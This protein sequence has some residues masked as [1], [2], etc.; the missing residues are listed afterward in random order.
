MTVDNSRY[1]RV[2]VVAGWV[3]RSCPGLFSMI[4]NQDLISP[5]G[6][7]CSDLKYG[8]FTRAGHERIPPFVFLSCSSFSYQRSVRYHRK[9]NSNIFLRTSLSP[10]VI[11]SLK[12]YGHS[13]LN[14]PEW[15]W[16]IFEPNSSLFPH[17]IC[18]E[19]RGFRRV[20]WQTAEQ[21]LPLQ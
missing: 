2:C 14:S 19:H 10:A 17:D 12:A 16:A 4:W 20:I 11:S 15:L 18:V 21:L 13:Q 6:L 7:F 8:F 9:E 1:N 3:R 5:S